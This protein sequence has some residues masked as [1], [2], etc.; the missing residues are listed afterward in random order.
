MSDIKLSSLFG[1]T[2]YPMRSGNS[3]SI[4]VSNVTFTV[5]TGYTPTFN[6]NGW[7]NTTTGRFTPQVAG[8][9]Q[10]NAFVSYSTTG[11]NGTG[12]EAYIYK[13]GA[14]YAVGVQSTGGQIG[15]PAVT[16]S[17][18][19]QFNGTSDYIDLRAYQN[20][21]STASNVYGILSAVLVSNQ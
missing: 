1:I 7:L 14:G 16:V 2:G 8:Y 12:V 20:S 17:D 21:G 6:V 19:V 4:S 13:N 5:M 3:T 10:I 9:Y 15:F 11:I 18:I